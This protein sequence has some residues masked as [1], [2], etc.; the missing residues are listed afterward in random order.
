MIRTSNAYSFLDPGERARAPKPSKSDLLTGTPNQEHF[1]AYGRQIR[2]AQMKLEL[3]ERRDR[4][5]EINDKVREH[6]LAAFKDRR[7]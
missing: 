6:A 4:W 1:N 5:G 7:A 2:A 3:A